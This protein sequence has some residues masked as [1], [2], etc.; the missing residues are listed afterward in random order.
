MIDTK[1]DGVP[2]TELAEVVHAGGRSRSKPLSLGESV[3]RG[4]AAIFSVQPLTWASSLLA[5]AVVPRFL[6][7]DGVGQLAIA[8]TIT[9]LASVALDLG[10]GSYFTRRV[11]QNPARAQRDVGFALVIQLLVFSMGALAIAVLAPL[12]APGLRDLRILYWALIWLVA[13]SAHGVLTA[14][15]RG[16]EQHVRYA[17][18]GAMP[19]VLSAVGA[20]LILFLGVDVLTYAWV[21]VVLGIVGLGF[22]WRMSGLRPILPSIDRTFVQEFRVF[23]RGGFPFLSWSLTMAFYGG[24]DRLLL[25]FFVPTSEVGWYSAAYSIIA[26]PVFIP[27]LLNT[28]LLPALSR[29]AHDPVVLRRAIAKTLRM[30]MLL[31][32]PLSVGTYV[33]ASV[34]PGLLGWPIDFVNAVP[35]MMILS[36]QMPI[37]AVDMVLGT[38]IMAI[39][40]EHFWV[41]L[42]LAA[43]VVNI[44]GNLVAIPFFEHAAGNG[45][46]G[47]SI[48]T[49][50]TEIW[51]FA[52]AIFIIPKHLFDSRIL[53]QAARII[54]AATCA[55]MIAT[56]LL[57]ITFVVSAV[58]GALTYLL[59]AWLLRAVSFED[60]QYI[61]ERL[62][63]RAM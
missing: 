40:R 26:I 43:A 5:A 50:L 51:M 21:G 54:V 17:W 56:V 30:T 44:V 22:S 57:P 25:G 29:N 35:L 34:V 23:V 10:I 36:I 42:G 49:G 7:S 27:T 16:Q 8:F 63:R 4:T 20:A 41:K 2:L 12:I 45:P 52:G 47:A 1:A 59:V 31:T 19:M 15:L 24:I 58:A 9:G 53:W 13:A 61:R 32:V 6:G 18:L 46:I 3:V 39:G 37:V 60:V 14:A 28:P 33:V 11:A 38:V 48:V 55:G 62:F